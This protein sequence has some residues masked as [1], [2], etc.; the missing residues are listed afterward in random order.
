[1]PGA[2]KRQ[3]FP[4]LVYTSGRGGTPN[5]SAGFRL[6]ACLNSFRPWPAQIGN[7]IERLN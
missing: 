4:G 2:K 6:A 7:L 1:M 5:F 3:P